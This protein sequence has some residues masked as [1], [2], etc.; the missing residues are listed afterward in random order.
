MHPVNLNP[1]LTNNILSSIYDVDDKQTYRRLNNQIY[2]E[3]A[4]TFYKRHCNK[5]IHPNEIKNIS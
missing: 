5:L 3:T 4:E 1:S 2:N